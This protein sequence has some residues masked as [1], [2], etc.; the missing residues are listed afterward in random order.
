[1]PERLFAVAT[2][3][4]HKIEEIQAVLA[5][6][7]I[8]VITADEAIRRSGAESGGFVM[9]EET[10]TTFEE[11][12]RIKADALA[13]AAGIRQ[14]AVDGFIADDSGLC[15]D[16][17]D[18]APGVYSARY[19]GTGS[20][21]DN[22]GRLLHELE[23]VPEEARTARFVCVVT[24]IRSGDVAGGTPDTTVFRGECEGSI[25]AQPRGRSGFG[26]DPV[27]IPA[28]DAVKHGLVRGDKTFAELTP[29]EK[30]RI[31]HRARAL[32]KLYE[33]ML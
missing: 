15:V 19:A 20:D 2:G 6:L 12:S 16:A 25:T 24:L 10:G 7:G 33:A 27:F 28:E 1:M 13:A 31:S 30:N 11:N 4:P 22:T 32:A 9:P 18:G 3:N 26:Y 21:T 5:P 8:R 17:L 23:G 14:E 29:E